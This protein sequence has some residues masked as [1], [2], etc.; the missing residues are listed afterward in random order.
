V[1]KVFEEGKLSKEAKTLEYCYLCGKAWEGTNV[2]KE[3]GNHTGEA[4]DF[5]GVL[6][7]LDFITKEEEALLVEGCDS[8]PWDLSQSGR[9]KQN[10]G[11][12]TN[13]KKKK[14]NGK[15]FNGFP[16]FSQFAQKKLNEVKLMEDFQTIEQC[17]I[18]YR[19]ETGACIDPHIDDCWVW[20]ERV[21]SVNLLSDS[22]LTM[23]KYLG[24]PTRYNLTYVKNNG[25]NCNFEN[26]GKED[27]P[28]VRIPMPVRSLLVL[29]GPARYEWEHCIY[30]TDI[31][32]R[33]ICMAYREFTPEYLE[34]GVHYEDVG[35]DV[36]NRAKNFWVEQS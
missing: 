15:T 23:S 27:F 17:A 29:Y 8:L 25:S 16:E 5:P 19:V 7:V 13:F 36:M 10:F 32:S 31:S 30:R 1:Q 11:P 28:L 21:V 3:H 22:V 9:R 14:I 4:L 33:R 12:K 6:V 35:L 18:E 34:G 20:G 2:V 26:G 24:P